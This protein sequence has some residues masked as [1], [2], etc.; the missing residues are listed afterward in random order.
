MGDCEK[1][2]QFQNKA[3]WFADAEIIAAYESGGKVF[4][5]GEVSKW[6]SASLGLTSV[7]RAVILL[8]PGVLL[9]LDHVAKSPESRTRYVG[10]FFHN[11]DAAF[12]LKEARKGQQLSEIF[13][14]GERYQVL[15][16]NSNNYRSIVQ[17]QS[18]EYPAEYKTRKTHYLNITTNLKGRQTRLAYVF[19]APGVK[20]TQPQLNDLHEGIKVSLR[21]NNVL[22]FISMVTNYKTARERHNFLGFNGYAKVQVGDSREIFFGAHVDALPK[23]TGHKLYLSTDNIMI[24]FVWVSGWLALWYLCAHRSRRCKVSSACCRLIPLRFGTVGLFLLWSALILPTS[25]LS[26]KLQFAKKL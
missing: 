7:Y 12:S 5:S 23:R 11:K 2:L 1:W 10:A 19:I 20:V 25:F 24:L 15:W 22:Q 8:H 16:A 13:L 6:Y 9:V 17:C 21:I 18:A 14:N 3:I 26:K 4:I